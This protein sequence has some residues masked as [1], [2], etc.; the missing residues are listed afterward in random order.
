[1]FPSRPARAVAG[2][3]LA[4]AAGLLLA[5]CG[6][7]G[8]LV[9]AGATATASGPTRLWPG[10]PP[11]SSPAYDYGEAE[12]EV[13]KGVKAPGG[14]IRQVDP[15]AVVRAE[16][17]AHPEMYSG[18]DAV[19]AG[20][21]ARMADCGGGA[22]RSRCPVLDAYYRDLTG[23]GREDMVL[24]F[25]LL[26][27]NQTAVRMYT[28]RTDRLVQVLASDDAV[29]AVELAGRTVIIRSPAAIVGYEYRTQW[30]WDEDQLAML[31]TRDEILRVGRSARPSPGG[32]TTS[33][34]TPRPSSSGGPR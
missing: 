27:G 29:L 7:S 11:A 6:D 2:A 33:A 28:V 34:A 24:G 22:E 8:G 5:A 17:A 1:M 4:L 21:T 30:T 10:E 26:P 16:I 32:G 18:S 23:D 13:V 14:N 3:S 31:L 15:V 12:T 20:T 19:Y 25:R 9:S